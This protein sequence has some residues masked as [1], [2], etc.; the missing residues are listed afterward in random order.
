MSE[1]A[2]ARAVITANGEPVTWM[3]QALHAAANAMG[4]NPGCHRPLTAPYGGGYSRGG[5]WD[6]E[7]TEDE[8]AELA[9]TGSLSRVKGPFEV[10][11]TPEAAPQEESAISS[12]E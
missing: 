6:V 11:F 3:Y 1:P 9:D 5:T 4:T 2:T 8:A 10:R 7:L 12:A